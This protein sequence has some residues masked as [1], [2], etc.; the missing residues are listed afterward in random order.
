MF[1][2]KVTIEPKLFSNM[3]CRSCRHILSQD[4]SFIREIKSFQ[5]NLCT[6]CFMVTAVHYSLEGEF[7]ESRI[8]KHTWKLSIVNP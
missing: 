8:E 6:L 2:L 5:L 7:S 1:L 4:S 3:Y